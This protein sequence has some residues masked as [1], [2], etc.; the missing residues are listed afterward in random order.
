[1][2]G[3]AIPHKTKEILHGENG[4]TGITCAADFPPN[5]IVKAKLA[6]THTSTNA[7]AYDYFHATAFISEL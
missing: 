3:S 6:H 1:M 2:P 5:M 7:L 4:E